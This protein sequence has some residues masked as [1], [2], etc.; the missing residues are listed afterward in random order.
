MKSSFVDRWILPIIITVLGLADGLLHFM[1]DF[2]LFQGTFIGSP[3]PPGP[4]PGAPSGPA[5][6]A[7]PPGP[8]SN[9]LLTHLNELFVL[10]AI[11]YVVL[12]IV[13]WLGQRWFGAWSWIVDLVLVVYTAASILGWLYVGAPNPNGLGY[14]SKIIEIVLIVALLV[15]AGRVA[16]KRVPA[17]RS[18]SPA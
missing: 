6:A 14:L 7:P 12:I 9:P 18:P 8:P 1:L 17:S 3:A 15:H 11:G 16:G 13:F 5:P 10:N 2:V 4:P